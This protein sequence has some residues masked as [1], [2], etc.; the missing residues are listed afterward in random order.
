MAALFGATPEQI[1][2]LGEV[3]QSMKEAGCNYLA[4]VTHEV[5]GFVPKLAEIG[6]RLS[7]ECRSECLPCYS[8]RSSRMCD[9]VMDILYFSLH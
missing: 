9:T 4:E 1:F 8:H 2:N 6:L 3:A 7:V 5:G